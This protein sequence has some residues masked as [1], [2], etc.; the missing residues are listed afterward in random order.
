MIGGSKLLN[1]SKNVF[2]DDS[3]AK[4]LEEEREN[5]LQYC[6]IQIDDKV[7]D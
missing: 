1:T 6:G 4:H 7:G 5:F 2:I 3:Y